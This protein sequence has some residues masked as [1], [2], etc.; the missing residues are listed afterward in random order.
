MNIAELETKN[1]DELIELL[2]PGEHDRRQLGARLS[3]Q[4]SAVRRVLHGGVIADRQTVK[5]NLD[6]VS[7]DL[8]DFMT[9][10]DETAIITAYTGEFLPE[11]VYDD[12]SSGTRDEVRSRFVD[13]RRQAEAAE[14]NHHTL[15]RTSRQ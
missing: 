9:A 8:E 12:W 4:L 5:L 6:E 13:C 1:R 14:C 3:V 2:W 10:V 7:T 15:Q 11:D